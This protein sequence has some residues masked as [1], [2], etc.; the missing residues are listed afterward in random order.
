MYFDGMFA[1][2][3]PTSDVAV[4]LLTLAMNKT[5]FLNQDYIIFRNEWGSYYIVWGEL[6]TDGVYVYGNDVQYIQYYCADTHQGIWQYSN[7]SDSSLTLYLNDG[8]Y[9]TSSV[10]NVG[11]VSMLSVEY[12]HYTK[13]IQD[14]ADGLISIFLSLS[15][16]VVLFLIWLRM[17]AKEC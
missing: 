4:D 17:G 13:D 3:S 6:S 9:P 12:E 16:F 11:F 1:S 2:V 10:E 8:A 14:S 15:C 7:G 5:D